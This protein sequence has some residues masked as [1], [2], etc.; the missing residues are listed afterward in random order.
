MYLFVYTIPTVCS[1]AIKCY[2]KAVDLQPAHIQAL[3]SLGDALF[4]SGDEVMSPHTCQALYQTQIHDVAIT[5]SLCKCMYTFT[6]SGTCL[7]CGAHSE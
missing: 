1:R 6:L 3:N 7:H 2:Q 5:I 4:V